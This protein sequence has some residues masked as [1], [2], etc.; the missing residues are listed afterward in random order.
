MN[1]N[2]LKNQIKEDLEKTRFYLVL[3]TLEIDREVA[4]F[5]KY[6]LKSNNSSYAKLF[7]PRSNDENF[8]N[9]QPSTSGRSSRATIGNCPSCDKQLERCLRRNNV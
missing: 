4:G 3:T 7:E 5:K 2:F 6:N 9:S 8:I 1:R